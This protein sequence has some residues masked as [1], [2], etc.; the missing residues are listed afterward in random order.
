MRSLTNNTTSK[1]NFRIDRKDHAHLVGMYKLRHG[2][3]LCLRLY[4][5]AIAVLCAVFLGEDTRY[6]I[7]LQDGVSSD[8]HSRPVA[9]RQY[10][11]WRLR[12][13]YMLPAFAY[14]G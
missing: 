11:R 7:A 6:A 1:M 10:R 5:R 13:L 9:S 14:T 8:S 12:Q 3:L 2:V 4:T